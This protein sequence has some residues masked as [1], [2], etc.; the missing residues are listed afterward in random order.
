VSRPAVTFFVERHGPLALLTAEARDSWA[1]LDCLKIKR[2][3]DPGADAWTIVATCYLLAAELAGAEARMAVWRSRS[4]AA[5]A[6]L[7]HP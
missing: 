5:V 4:R 3:I 1:G 2:A 7:A 6:K